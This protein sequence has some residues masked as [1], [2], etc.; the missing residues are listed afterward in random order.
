MRSIGTFLGVTGLVVLLSSS[1]LG[2]YFFG[3]SSW[4]TLGPIAFG[5]VAV[6]AWLALSYGALTE[7][8]SAKSGQFYGLTIG[9]GVALVA[10]L[11]GGFWLLA[12]KERSWDLT[13]SG[14]HSL[15]DQ[16][17]QVA[18]GL[19][20]PVRVTAFYEKG[21]PETDVLD[22]LVD[23]YQRHTN[24]LEYRRLSPSTAIEEVRAYQ[25]TEE[26][27]RVVVETNW[28][29]AAK[30]KEARFRIE[31]ADLNH[32]ES[33]TNALMQAG[34]R[35]RPRVY[36]LAGHG[37]AE[38][39]DDGP[40][41][42]KSAADD[43]AGEGY[44]VV[45]LNLVAVQRIPDD[46]TAII[47]PGP[48]QPLLEPEAKELQRWID[49]GG[50]FM[51]LLEPAT[52]PGFEA[53]LGQFGVQMN[54]DT[55]IDLSP[56]GSIF[57]GGPDTAIAVEYGAHPIVDKL[58]NAATIFPQARSLS[59][60]PGTQANPTALART[61]ERA[62]GETKL[63]AASGELAWDEGEVRGPV[64][65]GVAAELPVGPEPAKDATEPRKTARLVVFG[66]ASFASN[67]FK[68]LGS[69]RNLYLNAVGWLTAQEQKIAIRPN[70]RGGNRIVLTPSQREGIAFF[71]LYGLPV[72]ILSF[73][74]G[75]WLVRRQR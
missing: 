52:K 7:R 24:K 27:P 49:A 69:N 68:Q 12:Q 54:D 3:L 26:G 43:L 35:A 33:F 4:L 5:L 17:I 19:Q 45:P 29:D 36:F 66:D 57:G 16:S 56:F 73:G 11:A 72:A 13:S 8:L 46:A 58:T 39:R 51:L 67:Q 50:A 70:T 75:L 2:F 9:Y 15:S 28:A 34:Q 44:D 18:T 65:L 23:R 62:W 25:I 40:S 30:R 47:A 53:L 1:T 71:V 59:I 48:K 37:E 21:A 41:G 10:L 6:A 31:L 32:E 74:L 61:G 60:N 38:T 63:D 22:E 14:V 20:E 55:V 42:M 64:V